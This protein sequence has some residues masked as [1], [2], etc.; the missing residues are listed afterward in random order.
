MNLPFFHRGTR[1]LSGFP[2]LPTDVS[3]FRKTSF[4]FGDMSDAAEAVACAGIWYEKNELKRAME[5]FV[6]AKTV[7][8][9]LENVA[10]DVV[11]FTNMINI[12]ILDA[13]EKKRDA[14]RLMEK[15]KAH[16]NERKT[17]SFLPNLMAYEAKARMT[18]GDHEAAEAW[19]ENYPTDLNDERPLELCRIF[20]HLT[21]ARALMIKSE[22]GAALAFLR[23]LEKLASDFGRTIDT[24]EILTLLSILAWNDGDKSSAVGHLKNA[25]LSVQEF[26][27][28]RVFADEGASI[29]PVLNNLIEREKNLPEC[30]ERLDIAYIT[31]IRRA[32]YTRSQ[33]CIGISGAFPE[34]Q[35]ILTKQQKM[36][37]EYMS[38]GY[39]RSEITELTGLAADTIKF[40]VSGLY[41]KL[42]VHTRDEAVAKGRKFGLL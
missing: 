3:H 30:S 23:K 27:Y 10:L 28:V 17:H 33:K 22:P 24:A 37:L 8:S 19:L 12:A 14:T 38:K 41:R 32:A 13:M 26:R 39:G 9:D 4:V 21:T 42:D 36:V 15:L 40:H 11:F 29:L 16:L 6:F 1:D 25:I 31:E 7:L 18:N 5:C 35:P 20:Q 2:G 34:K